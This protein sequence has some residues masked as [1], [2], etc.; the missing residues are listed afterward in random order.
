MKKKK[1]LLSS[2]SPHNQEDSTQCLLRQ[3]GY[4]ADD[5]V[6]GRKNAKTIHSLLS[7]LNDQI[8]SNEQMH[9]LRFIAMKDGQNVKF[10]DRF[11]GRKDKILKLQLQIEDMKKTLNEQDKSKLCDESLALKNEITELKDI[12][13]SRNTEISDLTYKLIDAESYIESL[14]NGQRS[15]ELKPDEEIIKNHFKFIRRALLSNQNILKLIEAKRRKQ[16]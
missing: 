11:G 4:L 7:Q 9:K 3:I 5:Y 12:I 2:Q 15:S 8:T 10:S 16:S 6:A 13:K 1:I 14:E